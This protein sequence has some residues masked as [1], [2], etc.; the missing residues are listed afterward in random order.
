MY[1]LAH[2]TLLLE[3]WHWLDGDLDG[4]LIIV[5]ALALYSV[6]GTVSGTSARSAGVHQIGD[7]L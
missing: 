4:G 7:L 1:I 6:R 2:L 3:F 5:S